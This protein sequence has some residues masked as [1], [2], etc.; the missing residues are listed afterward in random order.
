MDGTL[1][2]LA[3]DNRFWLERVP[4]Q[5][6]E[7]RNLDPEHAL[8]DLRDRMNRVEGRLQWYCL[9]YW[10]E[11]LG[12]DLARMKQAVRHEIR[13]LPGVQ[14]FLAQLTASGRQVA[15]A[16]NAHPEVLSIKLEATQLD[17]LVHETHT[18]HE[19]GAAKESQVFWDGLRARM[20]FDPA[21]TL[22]VDDSLAVLIAAKNHGIGHLRAIARPDSSQPAKDIREFE[23]V[24]AIGELG[25][26]PVR[27]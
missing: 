17:R 8:A 22:F 14:D 16:T 9:D 26:V 5:Y 4:A 21:R 11:Q 15:I 3:F 27:R 20:G 18:A 6:A 1:L 24:D 10:S 25:P 23:A 19:F 12:F 2:D 13:I 7:E